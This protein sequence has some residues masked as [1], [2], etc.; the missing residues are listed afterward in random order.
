LNICVFASGSGTN[1]EAILDFIKSG[2]LQSQIKLLITNNSKCGAVDIARRNGIHHL[3][4]S[5]K[6][7]PGLSSQEYSNLFLTYLKQYNIDFIVLAGYMKMLEPGVIK[8]YEGR[9]INIHPS[10]LPAFGGAGMYGDNVHKAV[11]ES[12]AKVTGITIHFVED[13][14]DSGAVIFQKSIDV[15]PGDTVEILHKK[16]QKL[17]HKYFPLVLSMFEQGKIKTEGGEVKILETIN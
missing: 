12:G 5:K 13:T 8:A 2:R 11:L 1:F 15:E 4:I 6:V 16:V 17:E 14:Y 3:H 9:I 7:Y 10:L